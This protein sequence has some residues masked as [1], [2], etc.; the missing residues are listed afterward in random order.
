MRMKIC[1]LFLAISLLST[2]YRG[3]DVAESKGESDNGN[4]RK[5]DLNHF[6]QS[7]KEIDCEGGERD[8]EISEYSLCPENLEQLALSPLGRHGTSIQEVYEFL[9]STVYRPLAYA[10]V[11][12][13]SLSELLA[14]ISNPERRQFLL[15]GQALQDNY[16]TFKTSV[17]STFADIE[18]KVADVEKN[19]AAINELVVQ[20][21]KRFHLY[22][23]TLRYK[24]QHEKVR[25]D[26]MAIVRELSDSLDLRQKYLGEVTRTLLTKIKDAYFRFMRA[27]K[28]LEFLNSN[29][30]EI[31][32]TQ[33]IS[34]YQNN[35]D[36]I[37]E[38][39]FHELKIIKEINFLVHM[40]QVYN[41]SNYKAGLSETA[42]LNKFETQVSIRIQTNYEMYRSVL[43]EVDPIRLHS[44]RDFTVTLLL[45]A[46]HFNFIMYNFHRATEL[47]NFN[48][49]FFEFDSARTTK[50]Y[51]EVL[52]NM[53]VIPRFCIK[54]LVMKY[55]VLH[56]TNKVLRYVSIKY[57]LKRSTSGYEIYE[58]LRLLL[59]SIISA[60]DPVSFN[61]FSA[62]KQVYY[63]SLYARMRVYLE[64]FSLM[65]DDT[66]D[67]LQ[68]LV[69][70][71]IENFKSEHR[72][73]IDDFGIL[74]VMERHLYSLFLD[75][76]ADYNGIVPYDNNQT[77]LS[78]IKA[79]VH[80]MLAEFLKKFPGKLNDKTISVLSLIEKTVE[81]WHEHMLTRP[82]TSIQVTN[83]ISPYATTLSTATHTNI[84]GQPVSSLPL[85]PNF[86]A[87]NLGE[88]HSLT[89]AEITDIQKPKEK[90]Q[91]PETKS[92]TDAFNSF[93]A[94]NNPENKL[95]FE[96]FSSEKS[97]SS[98]FKDKQLEETG[99]ENRRR[100]V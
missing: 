20:I 11:P 70:E 22:W 60:I 78:D 92:S 76:K 68:N 4:D 67:E 94:F 49:M 90:T 40:I 58:Y 18:G 63:Q 34:R 33:I 35:C 84:P 30:S 93:L 79:R 26:T 21:L 100:A 57:H 7:L 25:E 41:Y 44:I 47:L 83:I 10:M 72:N 98:V 86:V 53:L 46:K 77:V 80:N 37:K 61:N 71:A 28:M 19:H 3:A 48:Q 91:E 17:L 97:T 50:V 54:Y 65:S 82:R 87:Q 5:L 16:V 23:N 75:M 52:D 88:G 81:N 1:I 9:D 96:R 66:V 31:L 38:S 59:H 43:R 89:P 42:S 14:D 8:E 27:S 51:N 6:F 29:S 32:V 45:K 85:P 56:E 74:D 64:H 62:F 73:T 39:K 15:D 99:L 24:N 12:K 36:L 95:L 69:G 55:C 13:S 2:I